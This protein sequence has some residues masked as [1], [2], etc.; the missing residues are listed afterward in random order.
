MKELG[1]RKF[2]ALKTK[3]TKPQQPLTVE[4]QH[5]KEDNY[6][7]VCLPDN[8]H[9]FAAGLF[10]FLTPIVSILI[11]SIGSHHDEKGNYKHV[12]VKVRY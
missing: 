4:T 7:V 2:K 1:A 9:F 6:G 3:D 5:K 10:G 8:S 12:S 11:I